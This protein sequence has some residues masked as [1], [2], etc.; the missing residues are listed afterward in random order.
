MPTHEILGGNVQ[1]FKRPRSPYWQAQAS[2]GGRQWRHSTK[3]ESLSLAKDV[4]EDW[5]LTLTGKR[6]AGHSLNSKTFAQAAK[7]FL[8]EYDAITEGQRSKRWAEGHAIRLRLHLIPYF[9]EMALSDIT[10]GKVQEY[11]VHRN[12]NYM[13]PNR[14]YEGRKP[15]S[16]KPPANKTLHNEI[17][18]LNL[19][20][21]TAVRHGWL[22]AVPDFSS[23]YRRQ[24]KRVHRPWFS[25]AE[26]TQLYKASGAH[27]KA[28]TREFYRWNAEQLHDY[29]LFLANTGLRPDEAKNLE[30]RDVEIVEDE[31]THERILVI[32]VRG[33]RGVG[34]CKS[35]P[36]A[37]RPYE[38]LLNRPRPDEFAGR[39]LRWKLQKQGL[40]I[41][42]PKKG[43]L[44]KPT[45]K[46]FPG[47][48]LKIF[49]NLLDKTNLKLDRDGNPRTAYSLRHSYICFRL[50]E[51]AD[52]YQIAKNCRT[53]V[54]MIE[55][56]YAA[57]IKNTLDASSINVRRMKLAKKKRAK[58]IATK[59]EDDDLAA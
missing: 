42:E 31:D 44:P 49:N 45:D 55:K 14:H 21:K 19:V 47:S 8:K 27:A 13:L 37:V 33:K 40:E 50:M 30:H 57:H 39:D 4:A 22:S 25:R 1:L 46:V 54:E 58:P 32:E 20:C 41:P 16:Q 6:Q 59:F 34:F 12:T 28:P 24:T 26:Y 29:I 51:G 10:A 9:G 43:E 36:N 7:Q 17:V 11:R 52:I 35:M 23:P 18:T 53:S 15:Q 38:R 5:Y 2:I 3:E 56:H 48:Y